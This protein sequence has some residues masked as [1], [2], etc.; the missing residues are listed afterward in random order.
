MSVGQGLGQHV[1]IHLLSGRSQVPGEKPRLGPGR[2]AL[3][4]VRSTLLALQ[5]GNLVPREGRTS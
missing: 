4:G 5:L 1:L 2:W 3:G